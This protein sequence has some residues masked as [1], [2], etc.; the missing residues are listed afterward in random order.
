MSHMARATAV[1]ATAILFCLA[2]SSCERL[3]GDVEVGA[4]P[5][6]SERTPEQSSESEEVVTAPVQPLLPA[7]LLPSPGASE[8]PGR[9]PALVPP[10][11]AG[12]PSMAAPG[13][14]EPDAGQP[15]ADPPAAEPKS[16]QVVGPAS[17]LERVGVVGGGPR[18]GVCAEG[19]AIG[20]QPTANPSPEVFGQ[21]LTFIELICGH[22]SLEPAGLSLAV[23]RDDSM[24][25]WDTTPPLEGPPSRE[26]PDPRVT[27]VLQPATLCPEAAPVLVG[28]SG[29]YD[30]VAPDDTSSDAIR[31]LVIECAPLVVAPNAVDIEAAAA[32]HQRI[33]QADSFAIPGTASYDSS[34]EAG[35]VVTQIHIDSGFWLDG[36]VLG[37]ARLR[38]P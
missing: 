5:A 31:S 1:T 25:T 38:S 22:V 18:F 3:L 4:A 26:V 15:D 27:W 9:T 6:R 14:S 33:S 17:E 32:G 10:S 28:L 34:C 24:L 2:T 12:T 23:V 19:V 21:R 20:V 35:S 36:F 16:V 30:P 13:T 37:C 29:Q 8:A 7:L 11:E